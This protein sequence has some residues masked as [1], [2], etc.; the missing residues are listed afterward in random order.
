[1]S[2]DPMAE[3]MSADEKIDALPD[4]GVMDCYVRAKLMKA[5]MERYGSRYNG[6]ENDDFKRAETALTK[7][8]HEGV[9]AWAMSARELSGWIHEA[10]A[11][12]RAEDFT[13]TVF[14]RITN[15][16]WDR[17]KSVKVARAWLKRHLSGS[18][19]MPDDRVIRETL[20]NYE[21]DA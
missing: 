15:S 11:D 12:N 5:M 9:R 1:M 18:L 17:E 19:G 13:V 3:I 4:I 20:K 7:Y 14:D 16:E 21:G 6:F 8:N 10:A 2:A